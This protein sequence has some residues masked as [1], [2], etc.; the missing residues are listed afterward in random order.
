M[1]SDV[2]GLLDNIEFYG[3]T[4]GSLDDIEYLG[5]HWGDYMIYSG[6]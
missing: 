4:M 6:H 2:L 3:D 1:T 5:V